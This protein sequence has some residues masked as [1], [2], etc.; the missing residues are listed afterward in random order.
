ME[1]R[2]A[3]SSGLPLSVLGLGCNSFGMKLDVE[4]SAAVV[5]AALESGITHFDTS[6]SY[7]GGRSEE[8]LGAVLS[9]HRDEVVIATK[10]GSRLA[11]GPFS[12][13]GS[14]RYVV[15]ACEASLRRLGTDYIDLYYQHWPDPLTPIDETLSALDD[16]VRAGKVRYVASSNVAGWQL[17]DAEHLARQRGTERFVATQLEWNLL[18]R[19]VE[20]ERVPAARQHGLGVVAY[21]PLASGMLTGKYARGAEP[22]VGSRM[23]RLPYFRYVMTD[24]AFDRV[25]ALTALAHDRGRSLTELALSWLCA[26]DGVASVLVG[27]SAPD[28]VRANVE[29][30]GWELT[31]EDLDAVDA[32]TSAPA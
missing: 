3:G 32:I 15:Q 17:A 4:Q 28:Q 31:Q 8:F 21:Y 16:L 5:A 22:P 11:D 25:E 1:H 7:G 18:S 19:G 26:R 9:G 20:R 13:G 6:D 29:A 14:R 10:F 30:A 2:R 24:D 12:G 27:A 23:D